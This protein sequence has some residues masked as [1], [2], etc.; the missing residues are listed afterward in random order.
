[1]IRAGDL[2]LPAHVQ[3][4]ERTARSWRTLGRKRPV[5]RTVWLGYIDRV[6]YSTSGS[7]I[8]LVTAEHR[9]LGVHRLLSVVGP[10]L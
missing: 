4:V 6:D 7:T 9:L 2:G 5:H 1:M 3:V 8:T 10:K